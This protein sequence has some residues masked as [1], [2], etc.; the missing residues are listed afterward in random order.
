MGRERV[1]EKQARRLGQ[2]VRFVE[3][4]RIARR[5][6]LGDALVAQH[7]VGEEEVMVDHHHVGGERVAP[8]AHHEAVAVIRAALPEAVVA[9]RRGLRPDRRV[10]GHVG[11]IGAVAGG[12]ES[13]EALDPVQLRRLFPCSGPAFGNRATQAIEAD[14]IRPPLQQ[15][16]A[17]PRSQRLA[18]RGQIA[19]E[20]LVLQRLGAGRDD[21]L[22]AGEERRDEV[23]E[24]LAGAG[25]CFGDQHAGRLDRLGDGVRHLHLA[26]ALAIAG[27][28]RGE[29]PL[30]REQRLKGFHR[31]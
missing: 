2:L 23:G 30:R 31:P 8:R 27:D 18:H 16:G 25:S 20:E 13:G 15:R 28:R 3:D 5:Q 17:S 9:R 29:R 21:D 1:A 12:A 6:Q 7:D 11:E 10:F 14:V 26:A 24:G 22:A 4:Q 19:V